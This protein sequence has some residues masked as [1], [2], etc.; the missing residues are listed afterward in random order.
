M[1]CQKGKPGSAAAGTGSENSKEYDS[2]K[3]IAALL[4]TAPQV[5][6]WQDYEGRMP[7]HLGEP[8]ICDLLLLGDV[9][10]VTGP[11]AFCLGSDFLGFRVVHFPSLL[12][13]GLHEGII[14]PVVCSMDCL[15]AVSQAF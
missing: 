14:D 7:L 12:G 13:M 3:C 4:E 5:L 9:G 6:N 2:V 15:T 11:S 10:W 1:L 8:V